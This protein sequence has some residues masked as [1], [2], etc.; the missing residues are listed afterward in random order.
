MSLL[1]T[2]NSVRPLMSLAAGKMT[3]WYYREKKNLVRATWS[4][5]STNSEVLQVN[6]SSQLLLISALFL[7]WRNFQL[8]WT[9]S[10]ISA[11]FFEYPHN[12]EHTVSRVRN[13]QIHFWQG[14]LFSLRSAN[15]DGRTGDNQ[16]LIQASLVRASFWL[17]LIL[18]FNYLP[19][20]LILPC[21]Q[22]KKEKLFCPSL[23][24]ILS[25]LLPAMENC[26][27]WTLLLSLQHVFFPFWLGTDHLPVFSDEEKRVWHLYSS[28][29]KELIKTTSIGE[30]MFY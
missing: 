14:I 8:A 13:K 23:K 12:F 7:D 28:W 4:P 26:L 15:S 18:A 11:N 22:W 5:W 29:I 25:L 30:W 10:Y 21:H 6:I 17:R 24:L 27:V 20:A 3:P 9:C 2:S 19:C 16:L 1:I